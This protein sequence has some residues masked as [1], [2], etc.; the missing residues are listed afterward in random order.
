MWCMFSVPRSC[1]T[2]MY[3]PL[4]WLLWSVSLLGEGSSWAI[5]LKVG[6]YNKLTQIQVTDWLWI[7]CIDNISPF[8]FSSYGKC[9]HTGCIHVLLSILPSAVSDLVPDLAFHRNP[10]IKLS[11]SLPAVHAK[12][13]WWFSCFQTLSISY[14][15]SPSFLTCLRFW[16]ITFYYISFL[17]EFSPIHSF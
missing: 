2:T 6:S 14:W 8:I 16:E 12:A 11:S 10:L 15:T 5:V 13:C 4:L 7:V 9:V 3:T 17:F 1:T